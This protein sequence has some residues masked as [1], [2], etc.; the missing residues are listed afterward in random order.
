[1]GL[2]QGILIRR[3]LASLLDCTIEISGGFLGSYFGM[4]LA[5]LL[6]SANDGPAEQMQS[7]MWSGFG[8]GL[9]F[10]TFSLSFLNRV[11]IQGLS[12]SSIGKKFFDLELISV[13][14]PLTWNTIIGRWVMGF[15][16]FG[17]FGAGYFSAIFDKEGRTF[18][19][20]ACHT[21]VVPTY[22]GSTMSVE[23]EE[24]ETLSMSTFVSDLRARKPAG[25]IIQ[26]PVNVPITAET[27]IA[28]HDS[29]AEV[30]EVDFKQSRKTGTNDDDS[31]SGSQAA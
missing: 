5:A 4:M 8:F 7:S 18:H 17:I 1:M 27:E 6:V 22:V 9:V 14:K 2:H 21:D 11:L 13:G 30:I 15:G 31:G 20:I 26:M 10:W 28:E 23:Y 29:L 24:A 3:T 16:S 25:T 12:R 19:D